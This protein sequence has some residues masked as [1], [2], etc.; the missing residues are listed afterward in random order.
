M[1]RLNKKMDKQYQKIW[2]LAL[3]YIKAGREKDLT[4]VKGVVK[5]MEIIIKSGIG[6]ESLLIPAAI[7]HDI[8]W[9]KVSKKLQKSQD[10]KDRIKALKLHLKY[11]AIIAAKVLRELNYEPRKIKKVAEIIKAHKFTNPREINKRILIDADALS[12]S[13][14]EQ[15]EADLKYYKA[16]RASMCDFRIKNNKFYTEISKRVFTEEIRKRIK[17]R[18]KGSLRKRSK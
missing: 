15:F 5:A 11:S 2:K 9:S 1:S 14:K 17:D 16:G 10:K 13:F 7:L 12:D 6:D 18:L 3:P 4:H 8:G